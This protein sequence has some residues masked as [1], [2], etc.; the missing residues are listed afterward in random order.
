M[1][2]EVQLPV[3]EQDITCKR[4]RMRAARPAR[5]P[6]EQSPLRRLWVGAAASTL[7]VHVRRAVLTLYYHAVN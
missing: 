2:A 5:L 6:T 4:W 3:H 7:C 1:P